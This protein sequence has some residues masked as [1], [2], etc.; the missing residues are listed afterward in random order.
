M[1]S[2]ALQPTR[3]ATSGLGLSEPGP[4]RVPFDRRQSI[5]FDQ[6]DVLPRCETQTV[7][8]YQSA[9]AAAAAAA[10]ERPAGSM[11]PVISQG[12]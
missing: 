4:G 5:T 3:I 1:R 12:V 7:H 2:L 6:V 9:A 8:L 10:A 11:T